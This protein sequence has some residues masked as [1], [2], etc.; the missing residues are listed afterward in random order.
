M[1]GIG[2]KP[3]PDQ[4]KKLQKINH[5]NKG[6]I[7]RADLKK[8]GIKE[9]QINELSS[10]MPWLDRAAAKVSQITHPKGW[11]NLV[12]AYVDGMK[13]KEHQKHPGAWAAEI[14]RQYRGV[15]GRDLVK[16]IN[17]LVDKGKLPQ[18][19]KAEYQSEEKVFTFKQFVETINSKET[20]DG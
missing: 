16:Y 19:L 12:K 13:D 20:K 1:K 15:E 11:G 17:K 5:Q 18:E 3:N 2:I 4:L 6:N 9:E 10:F 14:A 8:V 7:T